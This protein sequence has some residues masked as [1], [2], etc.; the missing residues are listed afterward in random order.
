MLNQVQFVRRMAAVLLACGLV[1][2]LSP[3]FAAAQD[4]STYEARALSKPNII[5]IMVDDLGY[6]DLGCYGSEM[7]SNAEHR[8]NGCR[9]RIGDIMA[10]AWVTPRSQQDDGRYPAPRG[11]P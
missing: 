2:S 8:Q 4:Q 3:G 7:I 11:N 6:H 9:G 1:A 10:E 5:F